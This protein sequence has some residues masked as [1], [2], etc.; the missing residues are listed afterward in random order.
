MGAAGAEEKLEK[1]MTEKDIEAYLVRKIREAGGICWKFT[2][3]GTRGVPDRWCVLNRLQFFVEL[4]SPTAKKR[5]DEKL[6]EHRA[7]QLK[8]QGC[9]VYKINSKYGA[10]FLIRNLMAG[11]LPD[12]KGLASL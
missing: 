7:K 3:P 11:Y 9:Y 1:R 8:E 2:S 6:Q 4:K 12:P 5:K 10:D